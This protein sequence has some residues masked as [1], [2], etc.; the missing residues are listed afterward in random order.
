[1]IVLCV[2]LSLLVSL[3][4]ILWEMAYRVLSGDYMRPYGD[5][6]DMTGTNPDITFSS[7]SPLSGPASEMILYMS[8]ANSGLRPR[9]PPTCPNAFLEV[10]KSAWAS[11]PEDRPVRYPF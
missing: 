4:I 7:L 11:K 3:S 8:V 9:L 10:L 2:Y 6:P 1:M 5:E